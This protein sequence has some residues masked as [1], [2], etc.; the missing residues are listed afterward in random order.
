MRNDKNVYWLD[1]KGERGRNMK[2]D[3]L[4]DHE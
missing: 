1:E 4:E 2:E 3:T